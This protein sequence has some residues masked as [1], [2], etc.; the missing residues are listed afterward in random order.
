MVPDGAAEDRA[1]LAGADPNMVL[2]LS[3]S[4]ALGALL[5]TVK[6]TVVHREENG[7]PILCL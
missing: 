4:C 7:I 5:V 2:L 1:N 3:P 6:N